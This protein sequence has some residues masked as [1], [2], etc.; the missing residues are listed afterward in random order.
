MNFLSNFIEEP[1]QVL[2]ISTYDGRGAGRA[3]HRLNRGLQA[4]GVDSQM[5]VQSK[6]SDDHSVLAPQT[7]LEK[8]IAKLRPSLSRLPLSFYPKRES[9]DFY[10]S[11][12]PD[13]IYQRVNLLQPDIINLHW[14]CDGLLEVKSLVKFKQ[15]LIWT[16]HDM[17]AF[18]GGCHYSQGCNRYIDTCGACPQLASTMAQDLSQCQW[19]RK[20]KALKDLNLTV[21]SPSEWLAKCARSSSI[22]CNKRVEV[23]PNGIDSERYK[24]IDRKIARKILRLPQDKRFILFGAMQAI[25]NRRKGFNLLQATL[26]DL[27]KTS[28]SDR[29]E[30][31]VFGSS[32]PKEQMD[33]GFKTH[34]LGRLSDDVALSLVYA[35]A[36]VFVAPSVEDN[37]PNTI[38][39]AI[40]CGTPCVAFNIGGMPDMIE[41]QKNGYLANPYKVED[42]AQGII[43]IIENQDRHQKLC[44]RARQKVEVEFTLKTQAKSYFEL[45][46]DILSQSVS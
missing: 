2:H 18:T 7:R 21:V 31:I 12:L 43:W 32:Q 45:Y 38:M 4:I 28:W 3:A 6:S 36:D 30:L 10:P 13:T 23:I 22:F 40:A 5:L 41:H 37:L 9:T 20:A 34:Y 8:G 11:W 27:S 26:N 39:E 14:L 16:L 24:P 1:V 25:Q 44:Q 29:L 17:W 46:L 15:P 19:Q 35:A 33:L 42:L